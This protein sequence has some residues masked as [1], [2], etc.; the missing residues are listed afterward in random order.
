MDYLQALVTI[1]E[2]LLLRNVSLIGSKFRVQNAP[3]DIYNYA[4]V[5]FS[6]AEAAKLGWI[7]GTPDDVAAK[8]AYD[9]GI[10]ASMSQ[11]GISA[12]AAT[13]YAAQPLLYIIRQMQ[14]PDNLS[15]IR[16]QFYGLFL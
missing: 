5:L 14:L 2:L 16:C 7:S 9:A 13:A 4:T 6:I 10:A 11:H 8:A 3:T 12:A 1:Q 15:K